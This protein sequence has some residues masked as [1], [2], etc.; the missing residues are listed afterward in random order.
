M[1]VGASRKGFLGRLLGRT[2]AADRDIATAAAVALSISYGADVV[3]VHN[4]AACLDA[5]RVADA[6]HRDWWP[7]ESRCC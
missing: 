4:V 3:R 1:L 7:D 5:V 6:V 2:E